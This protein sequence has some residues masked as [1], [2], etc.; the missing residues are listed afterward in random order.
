M[1]EDP[2]N[3]APQQPSTRPITNNES[4]LRRVIIETSF[5]RFSRIYP[6]RRTVVSWVRGREQKSW[7]FFGGKRFGARYAKRFEVLKF[8]NFGI[9]DFFC[10][11]MNYFVQVLSFEY[12][13]LSSKTNFIISS[14]NSFLVSDYRLIYRFKIDLLSKIFKN[15]HTEM[16]L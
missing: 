16:A 9:L 8:R 3:N 6:S 12:P 11:L 7:E 14:R 15:R 2:R 10:S 13:S 5:A 4:K 1:Q